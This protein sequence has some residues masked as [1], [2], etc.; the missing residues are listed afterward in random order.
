MTDSIILA[1]FAG[2]SLNLPLHM[3]LGIQD[4]GERPERLTRNTLVQWGMLFLSVILFW[5]LFSYVLSP[6][7]L[8]YFEYFL[9]FPLITAAGKGLD[10]LSR[11]FLVPGGRMAAWIP[12]PVLEDVSPSGLFP[13]VSAYEGLLIAAVIVT[14][15][16]AGSF[17]EAAVL[18]LGFSLGGAAAVFI[19]RDIHRRSSLERIPFTL[20]GRPLLFISMGLMS[21]IFSSVGSLLLQI[22]AGK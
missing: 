12:S 15:R 4:V 13:P 14:L 21:L 17:L 5:L 8:G 1:V 19:L 10:A 16:L 18:S 20:R 9:L 6:L 3:G 11:R 2:F 22:L 7:A